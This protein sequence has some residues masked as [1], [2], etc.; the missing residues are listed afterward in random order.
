MAIVDRI[1]TLVTLINKYNKEYYEK[2]NPTI[3]DAEYDLL[4]RELVELETKYP[5]YKLLNSPTNKVGGNVSR[6]F[7]EIH[8][9]T[10][11]LSLDNI[12]SKVDESGNLEFSELD[13]WYNKI[14]KA[15][16]TNPIMLVQPKYDGLALSLI[17]ENGKLV[18][19]VT[20]GDGNTGEDVTRNTYSIS[21]IPQEIDNSVEYLEVRGEVLMFK[22]D[23]KDLNR[24]QESLGK[25]KFVN[26]RNAA[27]GSL[28]Q[29]DS[30]I[31]KERKLKFYTYFLVEIK[32]ETNT[33]QFS[34]EEGLRSLEP[35]G[36]N[37]GKLTIVNSVNQLKEFYTKCKEE[38]NTLPYEID[39]VVYKVNDISLHG[40]L[41]GTSRVP[42]WAIAHKFPAQEALSTIE[43]IDLQVGRTGVVTP[44][45]RITPT[46]VS[47]TTISNVTLNNQ[48]DIIRK[49]IYVGAKIL[50]R[51]AGDVIPEIVKVVSEEKTPYKIPNH[52]PSCNT[53]LIT[54]GS[55]LR[56]PNRRCRDRLIQ[57]I[58]HYCSRDA[59]RI[60]GIADKIV[61]DLVDNGIVNDLYSLHTMK[62]EDILKIRPDV[63]ETTWAENILE[64]I[65]ASTLTKWENFIYALGIRHTGKSTAKD[66]V[67]HFELDK[68]DKETIKSILVDLTEEKLLKV[69]GI[70]E[71]TA[72][73][74]VEWFADSDNKI[75]FSKLLKE[76]NFYRRREDTNHKVKDKTFVITGSLS[77]TRDNVTN[78]IETKGGTVIN[79]VSKN[80][81]YLVVGASNG[82][83]SSK[84]KKAI[85]LGIKLL[86]EEEL[87][88]LI[89]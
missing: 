10:P 58:I 42:G 74:F 54:D 8:H 81:D 29:L 31:T 20:R 25:K 65:V 4:F 72:K 83:S 40:L 43:S 86:N 67:K 19:A 88:E 5:E 1:K 7:K 66:I 9:K 47:G 68:Y 50:I 56:C 36:F 24:K 76:L 23:F 70:G 12:F 35:L 22:S 44:V 69:E 79:S 62:L 16:G 48:F 11:M 84:Y 39:G 53:E 15:I 28:R 85:Q 45:A 46:F 60:D 82:A 80:T 18:R 59:M 89:K 51:R 61:E 6:G 57:S 87:M 71:V 64:N 32:T 77:S 41:P 34:L 27:A 30:S 21:G 49:G 2:D 37:I 38:R 52:C 63:K 55:Y 26:P 14:T 73:A 17:Y 3:S 75:L 78:L 33:K 13:N